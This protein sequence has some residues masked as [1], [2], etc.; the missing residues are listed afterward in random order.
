MSELSRNRLVNRRDFLQRATETAKLT[1]LGAALGLFDGRVAATAT[2]TVNP[3]AYDDSKVRKTDPNLLHYHEV[4]HFRCARPSPRCIALTSDERLLIGAGKYLTEH[5]FDGTTVSEIALAEEVRCVGAG[6]DGALYV[7]LRQHL[8]VFDRQGHRRETWQA[9][10]PKA[11]FTGVAVGE[12]DV[13]VAD[14]GNRAILRYDRSGRLKGRIGEK[15]KARNIPGLIVPSAFL[16]VEIARDGLLRVPNPG[17]HRVEAYSFDGDLELAWGT[18]GWAIENFCGCCN[19]I[20]LALLPNG[21]IVTF[22]KGIPRVKVYSAKG[23]F[24]WVVAGAESFV[25]NAK[26]CSPNDCTL[27]GLDGVADAKGRIYILDLVAA[28]TRVLE[29]KQTGA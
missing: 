27:G 23:A 20:N 9:A 19:P 16:D 4:G 7:G 24:E 13:F 2:P 26:V 5:S 12:S 3:W 6:K 25:A 10:G 18:P 8:E 15:D 1:G 29:R 14:A 22:E 11:Y 17:R 21:R 28:E